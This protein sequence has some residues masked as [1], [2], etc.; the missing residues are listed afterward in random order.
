LRASST[1]ARRRCGSTVEL[2]VGYAR[3]RI[4]AAS[5]ACRTHACAV[6]E[7]ARDGGGVGACREREVEQQGGARLVSSQRKRQTR[8]PPRGRLRGRDHDELGGARKRIWTRVAGLERQGDF[9]SSGMRA[10]SR[11][12]AAMATWSTGCAAV[13]GRWRQEERWARWAAGVPLG[14]F[15]SLLLIPSSILFLAAFF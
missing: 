7:L 9:Y 15:S 8:V 6:A 11:P 4:E 14:L 12:I 2:E 10:L 3:R 13:Q 5:T 1:P